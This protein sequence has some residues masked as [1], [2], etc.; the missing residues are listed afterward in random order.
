[1]HQATTGF[2]IGIRTDTEHIDRYGWYWYSIN[3]LDHNYKCTL[4]KTQTKLNLIYSKQ[5]LKYE[6]T[7][8][9]ATL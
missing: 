5:T 8:Y 4:L 1:M 9:K 2:N 3:H 6:A 7:S